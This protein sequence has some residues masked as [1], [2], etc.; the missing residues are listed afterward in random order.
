MILG[1]GIYSVHGSIFI[2]VSQFRIILCMRANNLYWTLFFF[3][4]TL[5]GKQ[6]KIS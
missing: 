1:I 2:T 3:S 6:F 4:Q 5:F